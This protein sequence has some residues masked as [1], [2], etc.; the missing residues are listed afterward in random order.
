[1]ARERRLRAGLAPASSPS[2]SGA[3]TAS[4]VAAALVVVF[5]TRSA[6]LATLRASLTAR[7]LVGPR[8]GARSMNTQ[9]TWGTGFPPISRPFSNSQ[10]Y[11]PWNSWNESFDRM[12]APARLAI[13]S[14]KASPRPMAPAGGVTSSLALTASS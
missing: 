12:L 5:A 14:T 7:R 3:A 2:L 10:G 9:P 11:S 4:V 8:T 1:L 6:A 13:C